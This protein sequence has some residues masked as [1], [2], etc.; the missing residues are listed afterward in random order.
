MVTLTDDGKVQF[1]AYFPGARSVRVAGDFTGWGAG[2]VALTPA[3]DGWWTATLRVQPGEHSFHYL[4]DDARWETDFAP[5]GV[6]MTRLGT[7]VSRLYV[8]EPSKAPA[9]A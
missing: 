8:P 7:W 5:F 3:L 4:V 1:R 9:L 6:E 2:P